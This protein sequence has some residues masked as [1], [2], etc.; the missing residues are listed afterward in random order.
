MNPL[1]D[2]PVL[3]LFVL[4]AVGTALG[5]IRIRGVAVGPAA[6]LFCALAFS[7]VNTKMALPEALGTFGLAVFAYSIG[8]TAGPSFFTSLRRG[9]R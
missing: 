2:S 6:V 9:A 8:V 1:I 7:A 4:L 3:L 5:S